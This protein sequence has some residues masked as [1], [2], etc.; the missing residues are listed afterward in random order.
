M[1]CLSADAKM[2]TL[3]C[4]WDQRT[5]LSW[6]NF[7]LVLNHMTH[8]F[9]RV[10]VRPLRSIAIKKAEKWMLERIE[11]TDGLGAIYPGHHEFH[12]RDALPGL[13]ARRSACHPRH[14]RI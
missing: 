1:N 12:R 11:M 2:P 14:G 13:F 5:D 6:R 8:W 3:H 9:E 4:T 10:H 7:F